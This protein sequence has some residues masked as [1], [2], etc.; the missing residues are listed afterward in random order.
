M[1]FL[2]EAFDL[3]DLP[4]SENSYDPIPEGWYEAVINKAEPKKTKDGT[5]TY[6]N[7]RYDI[8]GPTHQGRVVFSIIN[9]KNKSAIAQNIGLQNLKQLMRAIGIKRV[10]DT[11]QLIGG[12]LSIKVVVRT[13]EGY[14]PSN[15]VRGYKAIEGAV[16]PTVAAAP[17]ESAPTGDKKSPPWA[18][19]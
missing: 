3:D 11:D 17:K 18:K 13:Q 9:V 16:M 10:D 14:E 4:E 6:I 12:R 5:G 19:K 15:D 2:D 8:V 1:S 7:V